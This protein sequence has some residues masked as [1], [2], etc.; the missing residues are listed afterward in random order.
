MIKVLTAG[1]V[2]S[3]STLEALERI[4]SLGLDGFEVEFVRRINIS[5]LIARE[6][7]KANKKCY[8]SVHAPYF[9]NLASKDKEKVNASVKRIVESCRKA[10]LMGAENVV[11]HPGFY[12]AGTRK[13]TYEVIKKR[14]MEIL[15]QIKTYESIRLCPET[16]GKPS[17]FGSLEELLNL[18]RDTGCF[19]TVDFAHLWARSNGTMSPRMILERIEAED[20]EILKSMHAHFSGIEYGKKGEKNHLMLEDSDFPWKQLAESLKEF[21]VRGSIVCESPDPLFDA[22]KFKRYYE[23]L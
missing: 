23:S 1:I 14:V 2:G 9:I 6:I 11:F 21:K 16:S 17:Q 7:K 8:L 4:P 19:L 22:L 10:F 20:D 3:R 18:R 13:Q 12:T 15:E 5:D